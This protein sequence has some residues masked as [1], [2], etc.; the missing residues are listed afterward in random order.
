MKNKAK[1]KKVRILTEE[2][3]LELQ[4]KRKEMAFKKKIKT[5]FSD[6]GFTY[7]SSNNKHFHIGLR[8]VE[9]DYLSY[10]NHRQSCTYSSLSCNADM[11]LCRWF[12][13]SP[14]PSQLI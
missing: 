11:W 6:A 5:T 2:Q 1:K 4:K 12:A 9:L 14:Y 3:K 13:R 7:F 10:H 8:V